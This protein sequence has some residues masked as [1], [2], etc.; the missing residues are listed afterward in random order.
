MRPTHRRN[1]PLTHLSEVRSEHNVVAVYEDARQA[2]N[3][4][5]SLEA[6]GID[7]KDIS[8][9]GAELA[10]PGENVTE[11]AKDNPA[12]RTV[13]FAVIGGLVGAVIVGL[14]AA[15]VLQDLPLPIAAGLGAFSG[16]TVGGVI[17]A[18]MRIG[19]AEAWRDTFLELREGNVAVGVHVTDAADIARA[20]EVMEKHEPVGIDRFDGR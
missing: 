11:G 10:A 20:A 7:G 16:A 2:R 18:S 17:G 12:L 14:V 6:A 15:L 4:I 3:V 13:Q 19:I 8:L 1:G 9:L 5:E